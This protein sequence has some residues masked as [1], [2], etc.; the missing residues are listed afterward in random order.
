M[1]IFY[2]IMGLLAPISLYYKRRDKQELLISF[3]LLVGIIISIIIGRTFRYLTPL[4][5][6]HIIAII[7]SY[8]SYL[9]YIIKGKIYWYLYILP[10]VTLLSYILIA[11]LG[12][13]HISGF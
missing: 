6:T 3:L 5:L 11:F 10:F 13:R 12:N 1:K 4:F 2:I 8:I 7:I 9:I